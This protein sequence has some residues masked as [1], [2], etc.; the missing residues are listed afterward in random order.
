MIPMRLL[1]QKVEQAWYRPLGWNKCLLPLSWAFE[2]LAARRRAQFASGQRAVKRVS[3]PVIVVGNISVGGTGKSPLVIFLI[4]ALRQQG[5]TPGVISRG[6]GASVKDFPCEVSG[7]D[8]PDVMGDEPVMIARRTGV[9]LVIDPNR[10]HA[11]DYL[12]SKTSCDVI[13][14]D[15]GLQH[16]ALARDIEIAVVDGLK[17]LGNGCCLPVGP[18]REPPNRLNEVDLVVLNQAGDSSPLDGYSVNS[19]Y[20]YKMDIAP[21]GLYSV[22]SLVSSSSTAMDVNNLGPKVH[23]V[24]G[25]GN[26][27]RFFASLRKQGFDVVEHRF[28]DHYQYQSGDLQFG[29]SLAVVMTEKDAIKCTHFCL[30][31]HYYLKV[32]SHVDDSMMSRLMPLLAQAKLDLKQRQS[33]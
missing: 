25:I 5:W 15:D 3:V 19:D 7:Q 6:Y 26:P 20:L 23:G 9:P 18:L 33:A 14:S 28:P 21:E 11:A 2:R 29:D 13:I 17:G 1:Q 4:E 8:A 31:S 24:A 10:S 12:L 32:S 30:D 16:Y 22:A 27:D